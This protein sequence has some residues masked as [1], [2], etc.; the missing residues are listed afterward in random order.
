[1]EWLY[2]L[3]LKN[4]LIYVLAIRLLS[5]KE[6]NPNIK[7]KI[8]TTI[9]TISIMMYGKIKCFDYST[10]KTFRYK[11]NLDGI[12]KKNMIVPVLSNIVDKRKNYNSTSR[13]KRNLKI[14]KIIPSAHT[15]IF[16]EIKICFL[17]LKIFL[18]PK[19]AFM[20]TLAIFSLLENAKN[21][22][23]KNVIPT[24]ISKR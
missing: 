14:K 18:L 17:F 22:S 20:C 24:I 3:K 9:F 1:M 15:R 4:I 2:T 16:D 23:T 19:N 5:A 8:A 11:H 10:I 7:R 13:N 12:Y 6:K 21:P